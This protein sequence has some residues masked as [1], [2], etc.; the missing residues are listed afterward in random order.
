MS[1]GVDSTVTAAL[2]AR[3]GYDV[4]GVTLQLYDHG[5]AIQTKGACCAGPDL[6]DARTAAEAARLPQLQRE[7]EQL[8]QRVKTQREQVT[9]L[10]AEIGGNEK[11]DES[12][13]ND[14][15]QRRGRVDA[16]LR[17]ARQAQQA[18]AEAEGL[19]RALDDLKEEGSEKKKLHDA[20]A[21]RLRDFADLETRLRE[22]EEALIALADP[23][24]R[25]TALRAQIDRA[26]EWERARG[27]GESHESVQCASADHRA[28]VTSPFVL[29]GVFRP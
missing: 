13:I 14:L 17:E 20:E 25:A 15:R 6:H 7:S 22:T 27:E 1:G 3:A 11:N 4:V 5:A 28:G 21:A 19:R 26:P 12:E 2:M 29:D 10:S 8:G 9:A 16:K 18:L 23:R 24:G